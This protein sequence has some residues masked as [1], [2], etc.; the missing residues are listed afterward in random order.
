MRNVLS[1]I[2]T[3]D[4]NNLVVFF[5]CRRRGR[6]ERKTHTSD[7]VVDQHINEYSKFPSVYMVY[8]FPNH[9]NEMGQKRSTETKSSMNEK[10]KLNHVTAETN[11]TSKIRSCPKRE[12]T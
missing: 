1:I 6:K 3:S 10:L 7:D 12:M 4:S 5:V 11:A 9:E 8:V 2:M